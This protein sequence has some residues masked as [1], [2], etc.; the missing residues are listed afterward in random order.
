M[1]A[2]CS[3]ETSGL[4]RATW[5]NISEDGILHSHRRENLKS[6]RIE[7]FNGENINSI[8]FLIISV[9]TQQRKGE[10]AR[11]TL[12]KTRAQ[13]PQEGGK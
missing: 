13:T 2:I 7:C 11:V 8:E 9:L 5:R 4:R 3:S 1:E 10:V 6:Y 12:R